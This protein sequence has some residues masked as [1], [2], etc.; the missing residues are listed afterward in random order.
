MG[1]TAIEIRGLSKSFTLH[2]QGGAVLQ[3]L[4]GLDLAVEFGR[5]LALVGPSGTGKSTLLRTLYANYK[6]QAGRILVRH[7]G[8]MKD[9][10]TARPREILEIRKRTLGH[11]SQFLRVVPRVPAQEVVAETLNALVPDKAGNLEKAR[12]LLARLNIGQALWPLSPTTF[13]G[14]EQQRINVARTFAADY[15]ILLLDEPT[16]SLDDR[17]KA[18]VVDLINR[19]KERG[20]ALVGIFHDLEVRSAVADDLYEMKPCLRN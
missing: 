13:S 18:V 12:R 17:N 4:E 15:P 20:A 7:Q 8:R 14:G 19:A 16:A 2:T 11:V 3:V 5:C 9:M 10:A 1:Q 6:P